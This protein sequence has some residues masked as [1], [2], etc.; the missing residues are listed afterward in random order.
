MIYAPPE[1]VTLQHARE[2]G[3]RVANGRAMN[4]AQ[5]VEAFAE[6]ICAR[7]LRE[8]REDPQATRAEVT[9]I[10]AGAWDA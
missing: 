4:I 2:A 1:T 6:H 8:A 9:R 3:L 10:M 7:L 5:A